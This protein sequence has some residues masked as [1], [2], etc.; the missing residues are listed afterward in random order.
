MRV[1]AL[2][3]AEA[4]DK[5]PVWLDVAPSQALEGSSSG[6]SLALWLQEGVLEPALESVGGLEGSL[7]TL[8]GQGA[9]P[10]RFDEAALGAML[11]DFLARVDGCEASGDLIHLVGGVSQGSLGSSRRRAAGVH[12]TPV[13]VARRMVGRVVSSAVTRG[14]AWALEGA[15]LRA[16][17]VILALRCCDLAV[18]GGVF[19]IEACRALFEA[20]L[21]SSGALRE[22]DEAAAA[23]LRIVRDAPYG[24]DLDP[25]AVAAVRACLEMEGGRLGS[26]AFGA[27][28]RV[29]DGLGTWDEGVGG[30]FDVLLGNPPYLSKEKKPS[31]DASRF[32]LARGS[33]DASWLFVERGAQIGR[34]GASFGYVLPDSVLTRESTQPLRRFMASNGHHLW[35]EHAGLVFD[36]AVSAVVC[37]GKPGDGPA[38]MR[39]E[40]Q[41]E[42]IQ[43][44]EMGLDPELESKAWPPQADAGQKSLKWPRLGSFVTIRRGEETGKRSLSR[45]QGEV[46]GG[47]VGVLTGE[48]VKTLFVQPLPS[49]M[50]S[51]DMVRKAMARYE[52]PKVVVVK[53]GGRVRA[54]LDR[55]GHVT[56][57]SIYGVSLLPDAP[58]WFSLEVVCALLNS[59]A[60]HDRW[61]GPITQGKKIFPQITQRMLR[62]I[63]VPPGLETRAAA[64]HAQVVRLVKGDGDGA[65]LEALIAEAFETS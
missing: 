11:R 19:L 1:C 12:Y 16:P 35:V 24:L 37:C 39:F 47:D 30:G 65:V 14:S 8:E 56:L 54:A 41:G 7:W 57:Q 25:V 28:V 32:E 55:A 61:I 5:L 63:P 34:K 9:C 36:A 51:R 3:V 18:G 31:V 20:W 6:L 42:A 4:L 62:D 26:G 38:Q 48:S 27:H 46:G 52:G 58:A 59:Q 53:T 49:H 10:E 50:M 2:V 40:R 45:A 13:E 43:V 64:I 44:L 15:E 21:L 60:V 23:W 22:S 29:G 33:W 17:E